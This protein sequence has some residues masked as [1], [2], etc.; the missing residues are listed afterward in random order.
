ML[1]ALMTRPTNKH[2]GTQIKHQFIRYFVSMSYVPRMDKP[3]P[4]VPTIWDT[5]SAERAA[6]FSRNVDRLLTSL[7]ACIRENKREETLEATLREIE[8]LPTIPPTQ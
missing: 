3:Q 1:D 4:R 2:Q 8:E 7:D 5:M 6:E